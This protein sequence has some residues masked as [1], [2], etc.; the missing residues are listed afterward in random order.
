MLVRCAALRGVKPVGFVDMKEQALPQIARSHR[1]SVLECAA[2]TG[3]PCRFPDQ[4]VRAVRVL[5]RLRAGHDHSADPFAED[6]Q[7]TFAL[8]E[9][10]AQVDSTATIH[11]S[12]VL[13]GGRVERD[14]VVVRS[15]VCPGGVVKRGGQALDSFV[16]PKGV[17][18]RGDGA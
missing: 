15:V 7:R 2:P 8:V 17:E 13:A 18:T 3:A 9:E 1:V 16:A 11:D 14:A 4:Y 12:I 6:W 10:Q 5:A